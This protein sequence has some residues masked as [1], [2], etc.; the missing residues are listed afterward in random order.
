[1]STVC[2]ISDIFVPRP[3]VLVLKTSVNSQALLSPSIHFHCFS[4]LVFLSR[5]TS[6][7]LR[8]CKRTLRPV[9]IILWCLFKN[10]EASRRTITWLFYSHSFNPLASEECDKWWQAAYVADLKANKAPETL[11][12]NSCP[13]GCWAGF[14]CCWLMDEGT[15]PSCPL[16]PLLDFHLAKCQLHQ[17]LDNLNPRGGC[18]GKLRCK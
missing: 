6:V 1:M 5:G 8:V 17:S 13:R 3:D 12:T 2:Q 16:A 10:S 18:L 15:P 11:P 7:I 14:H 9:W 4:Y